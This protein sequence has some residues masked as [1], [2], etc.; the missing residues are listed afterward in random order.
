MRRATS[1]LLI[2]VISLASTAVQDGFR[3][4]RRGGVTYAQNTSPLVWPDQQGIPLGLTLEQVFGADRAP[5][6]AILGR[7]GAA[8][9]AVGAGGR[10]YVRDADFGRL[11]A[12]EAD[13]SVA[14]TGG[15]RGQGPGEI[16]GPGGIAANETNLYVLNQQGT[17]VD[18][19]RADGEY[20]E[21]HSLN[22][23][24]APRARLAGLQPPGFLVLNRAL[25]E[26]LGTEITVLDVRDEWSVASSFEVVTFDGRSDPMQNRGTSIEARAAGESIWTGSSGDY[27]LRAFDRSGAAQRIVSLD[28]EYLRRPGFYNQ[29]GRVSFVY[30]GE[31]GAPLRLASGHLL[32]YSSWATNVDDPA[33]FARLS[34]SSGARPEIQWAC[35]LDLFDDNG[36]FLGSSVWEGTREPAVGQPVAATPGFLYT[37]AAEPFPQI[38][39]YRVGG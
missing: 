15:T 30:L 36:R 1:P 28:V 23:L 26:S 5:A 8:A 6:S 34:R 16:F 7:I 35:S 24:G 29:G 19:W 37:V 32:V 39:R 21:S 38:R 4:S 3:L 10:V 9:V 17:R 22:E 25:A 12:F 27:V 18:V 20:L 31:V 11:V 33:A 13:G 2:L 14:W